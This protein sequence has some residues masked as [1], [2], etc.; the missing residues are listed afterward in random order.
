[1]LCLDKFQLCTQVL[2]ISGGIP[3][4]LGIAEQDLTKNIM[5]LIGRQLYLTGTCP[6]SGHLWAR[7]LKNEF[8]FHSPHSPDSNPKLPKVCVNVFHLACDLCSH[9][10]LEAL[11]F[12]GLVDGNVLLI[13]DNVLVFHPSPSR[14][15]S[16]T[17]L[18][19]QRFSVPSS[20]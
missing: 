10:C 16:V 5:E 11:F 1:M 20:L 9:E 15:G 14:P 2:S 17:R 7:T 6:P 8:S 18:E 13:R 19:N 3:D 12:S 4:P